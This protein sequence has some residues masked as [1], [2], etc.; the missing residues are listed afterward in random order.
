MGLRAG[1][2]ADLRLADVD[3]RAGEIEV[4]GRARRSERLP[5][6]ADVGQALAAYLRGGRGRVDDR[7]LF[8]RARAP[9]GPLGAGG[10]KAVV[11]GACDRAGLPRV[12]AHRLRRW[13]SS[14]ARGCA[15]ARLSARCLM[16]RGCRR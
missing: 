1:E 9:C 13:A 8:V 12:G 6:P 16:T 7:T 14:Q 11:R 3:W 15:V 10:V 4:T 5:L 2:V